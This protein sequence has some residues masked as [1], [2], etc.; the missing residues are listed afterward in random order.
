MSG[1][2][3]I[4]AGADGAWQAVTPTAVVDGTAVDGSGAAID[5][6]HDLALDVALPPPP[7]RT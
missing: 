3:S 5:D 4:D 7:G 1:P 2:G 6:L